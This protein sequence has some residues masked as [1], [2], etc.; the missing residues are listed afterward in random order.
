MASPN[1]LLVVRCRV[2]PLSSRKI[3]FVLMLALT[4]LLGHLRLTFSQ[5]SQPPSI[6]G[7]ALQLTGTNFVRASWAGFYDFSFR[8]L[9]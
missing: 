4:F 1:R 5:T 2:F 7:K 3:A 8:N 6:A 9:V